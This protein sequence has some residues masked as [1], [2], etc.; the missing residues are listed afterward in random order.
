MA[1]IVTDFF[2]AA[3]TRNPDAL[4][5]HLTA[6]VRWTFGN[7]PTIVGHAAVKGALTP[8]FEHVVEMSHRI[9][10]RWQCEDCIVAETRVRY[11]DQFGRHFEF[12]GCDLLFMDGA[13]IREVRIFVDNHQLFLPPETGAR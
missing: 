1:D 4:L 9:V 10:G 5:R 8:L 11:R 6:D 2:E 7:M 3:D 13:R 12:P